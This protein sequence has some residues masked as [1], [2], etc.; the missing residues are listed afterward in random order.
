MGGVYKLTELDKAIVKSL[1]AHNKINYA[2]Q[3]IA[4]QIAGKSGSESNF[5][6][7]ARA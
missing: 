5:S 4:N 7:V 1:V 3:Y 6:A 2:H